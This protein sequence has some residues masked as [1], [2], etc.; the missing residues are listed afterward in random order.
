MSASCVEGRSKFVEAVG[1]SGDNNKVCMRSVEVSG[2]GG[3][4]WRQREVLEMSAK[5][6]RRS[7]K[8]S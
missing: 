8:V 3:G 1:S 7:I 2:E 6:R 5:L 4:V